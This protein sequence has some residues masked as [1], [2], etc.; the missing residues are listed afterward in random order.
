[1]NVSYILVQKT[2]PQEWS[3]YYFNLL[4]YVF[5]LW[6]TE[7]KLTVKFKSLMKVPISLFK[8]GSHL[9]IPSTSHN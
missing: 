1:M 2:K 8:N 5:D 9:E 7:S 3:M 6:T 4:A